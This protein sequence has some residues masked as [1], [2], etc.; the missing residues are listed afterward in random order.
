MRLT[1]GA[2]LRAGRALLRLERTELARLS[3]VSEATIKRLERPDGKFDA[4]I[5]TIE[6]LERFFAG[7]KVTFYNDGAPG[8]RLHLEDAA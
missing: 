2:Q 5:S 8:A 1:A 4:R 6:M 7:R 3:G